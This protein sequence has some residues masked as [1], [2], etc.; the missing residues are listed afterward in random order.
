[1]ARLP[2]RVVH[3]LIIL[4]M[5]AGLGSVG[6]QADQL[7]SA[8]KRPESI[9]F[10]AE[11][12]Y[13]PEKA[14]LGKMLYF[15]PRVSN[16]QNM[17]CASCHNPSFGWEAPLPLAIGSQNTPLGRHAPT[18]LNQAWSDEFFWD[19][20]SKTLEDQAAGPI[21]ADVEMNMPLPKLVERLS[22]IKD[23]VTWFDKVFP[24]KG[25][26][27]KTI[28]QAIATYERTVVASYAPFDAWVDGDE[29]ALSDSAKRGFKLFNGKARCADCHSGWNFT[30]NK[31]H[32]IGLPSEDIGRAAIE[33]HNPKAMFAFKTPGLRDLTQRMP[34][35]HDG[36]VADLYDVVAH[37]VSGGV[38]R[39]SLS[40]LMK[41]VEL[42]QDEIAD[43][44][45]F[46]E[47]LTGEKAVVA[48]PIL[49]N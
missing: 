44:I 49:P 25:I 23:Y 2:A 4:G 3:F 9:P 18:V 22:G 6:V 40:P 10:P 48:L 38:Q 16:G 21:T 37:Y 26:T 7:A 35:M 43:L 29:N 46:M 33:K 5:G 19:G 31:Y 42:D 30:D 41:P 27:Q 39:P 12:P 13:T 32:D 11:N 47:S 17:N 8:Y 34:F 1:M 45:A 28:L 14:A 15:D 36:S 20:R 24:K